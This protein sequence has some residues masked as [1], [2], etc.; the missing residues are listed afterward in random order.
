VKALLLTLA[1]GLAL[2][3]L[4]LIWLGN[5][6]L[7]AST[8]NVGTLLGRDTSEPTVSTVSVGVGALV[9]AGA[10]VLA[11]ALTRRAGQPVRD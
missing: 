9:V 11:A 6:E 10:F 7:E 5:S 2:L 3:G 8:L 1:A 4:F